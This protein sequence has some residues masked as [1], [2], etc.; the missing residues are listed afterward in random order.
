MSGMILWQT[1]EIIHGGETNY[2]MATV[3][4]YITIFNLLLS[5]LQILGVVSGDD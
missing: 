1:S 3:S 4:R 2:I 5:L